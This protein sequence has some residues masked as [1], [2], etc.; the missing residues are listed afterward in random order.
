MRK[1]L[2]FILCI[3]SIKLSAQTTL[4]RAAYGNILGTYEEL[5]GA[6]NLSAFDTTSGLGITWD[7][8]Q[9]SPSQGISYLNITA[10]NPQGMNG[11]SN[12]PGA[13]IAFLQNQDGQSFVSYFKLTDSTS[14]RMGSYYGPNG[15]YSFYSDTQ[16]ELKFP[17]QYGTSYLDDWVSSQETF[18]GTIRVSCIGTGT[19]NLP[20]GSH[21]A[22][23]CRDKLENGFVTTVYFWYDVTDGVILAEYAPAGTFNSAVG[24][25]MHDMSTGINQPL[26]AVDVNYNNPVLDEARIS[27]RSPQTQPWNYSVY[28]VRGRK[29]TAGIF[30][31][32]TYDSNV[33]SINT[34]AWESGVYLVRLTSGDGK[35]A[36]AIKLVKE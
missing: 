8:T 10:E 30:S 20:S 27:L 17:M 11:A 12:Y 1:I 14:E 31:A 24:Y 7:L 28:D 18:P 29:I 33:L 26:A 6:S 34:S 23:L 19:V 3:I 4:T 35:L 13:N 36:K 32:G 5:W 25:V 15:N 2:L 21:T 16:V 9:T 22:I